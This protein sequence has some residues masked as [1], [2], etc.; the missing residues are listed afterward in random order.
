MTDLTPRE[1]K[2]DPGQQRVNGVIDILRS[3]RIAGWAIDRQD[4]SS[5]VTVAIF[6]DGLPYRSVVADRHRPDLEKGGIGT[7][8]YGFSVEIDPPVDTGLE[9]MVTAIA[10]TMDGQNATL[11]PVG[12]ADHAVKP[13]LLM[14]SRLSVSFNELKASH[15]SSLSQLAA[16]DKLADRM[17]LTQIRL[18]AAMA[19]LDV[20]QSEK[21]RTTIP[22]IT[23]A[24]AVAGFVSLAVGVTS[25]WL[26]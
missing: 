17:E 9:F 19:E 13:E 2:A 3:N 4:A 12:A 16:L 11:K 1:M 25:L 24:V 20:K 21:E 22:R 6:R 7:G 8:R 5:A 10:Q 14:L 15:F 26:T 18:E 23:Y